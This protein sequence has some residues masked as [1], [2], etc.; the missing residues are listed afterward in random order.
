M[1]IG[2]GRGPK[3]TVAMHANQDCLSGASDFPRPSAGTRLLICDHILTPENVRGR[4][5]LWLPLPTQQVSQR[6][7]PFFHIRSNRLCFLS[8]HKASLSDGS[9]TKDVP[10]TNALGLIWDLH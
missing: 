8:L 1:K 7:S 10:L 2:H 9:N 6:L 4:G 3:L 5:H